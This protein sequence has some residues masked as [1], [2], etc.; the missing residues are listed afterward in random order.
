MVSY[1]GDGLAAGE[2]ARGMEEEG[3]EGSQSRC[4][5]SGGGGSE[6]W[7]MKEMYRVENTTRNFFEM[8]VKK[9]REGRVE[10]EVR[11][12]EDARDRVKERL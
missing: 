8:L 11:E 5:G 2:G 7:L 9:R 1:R 3:T 6:G 4:G 12:L 10:K